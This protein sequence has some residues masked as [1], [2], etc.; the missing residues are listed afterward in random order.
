MERI[1]IPAE[2]YFKA[3]DGKK[4]RLQEEC[5]RWEA[6][7]DKWNR[8]EVFRTFENEDGQL[9]YA[10]WIETKEELEDAIWFFDKKMHSNTRGLNVIKDFRPRWMVVYPYYDGYSSDYFVEPIEL[11]RDTLYET[12]QAVEDALSEVTKLIW[13]K[14]K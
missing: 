13:E 6:A 10:F 8:E 11:F 12:K 14:T 3:K 7:S 5:E 9:C 1:E 2:V 4:F